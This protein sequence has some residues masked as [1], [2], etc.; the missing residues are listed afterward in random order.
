MTLAF[1]V[2]SFVIV[3]APGP[4]VLFTLGTG[5]AHGP[6]A[7]IVAATACTIGILPHM[8]AAIFGLTALLHAS[9]LLFQSFK[10]LGV[11][12]LLYMAWN[13][14]HEKGALT[15]T[16]EAAGPR[17]VRRILASAILVNALNPKL[18]IF[19]VAFLPQF[20]S[21]GETHPL[22]HMLALSGVFMA[23]TLVVFVAYGLFAASIREHIISRP[24]VLAWMRWS[25]AAAFVG[26]GA[27]L[28]LTEQ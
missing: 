17:P 1:L 24:R 16:Q 23:M 3:I 28:A 9:A 21:A 25:F 12:F 4:G 10:Y 6:R 26:L 19:F 7:A 27:K 20:V 14:L 2:T 13:T 8:L 15:V 5:L 18:T 22:P 11:A